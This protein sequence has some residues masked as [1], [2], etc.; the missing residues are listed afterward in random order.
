MSLSL[1]GRLA[2]LLGL[3]LVLG[4]GLTLYLT[5][6]MGGRAMIHLEEKSFATLM[7]EEQQNLDMTFISHLA[8]RVRAVQT[9]KQQ[10]QASTRQQ[11]DL[12][13]ALQTT[14]LTP[15]ERQR[16]VQAIL[17][18]SRS[19]GKAVYLLGPDDLDR[20]GLIRLGLRP[21]ARG[22]KQRT[23]YQIL[24]HLPPE[25][26]FAVVRLPRKLVSPDN[27]PALRTEEA[28]PTLIFFLPLGETLRGHVL[29]ALTSLENLDALSQN[30][31]NILVKAYRDKFAQMPLYPDGFIAL[32]DG[33]GSP[34]AQHGNMDLTHGLPLQ[35]AA[36]HGRASAT[37][38]SPHG[39][40]LCLASY[41]SAFDWYLVIAAPMAAIRAPSDVL[42]TRLLWLGLALTI[43]ATLSALFLL[44][45]AL[46]PL[47]LLTNKT[48]QLTTTDLAAPDALNQLESLMARGLPLHRRDEIGS[49]ANAFA[50]MG[51]ALATN[52][53]TLMDATSSRERLEG[54]MSAAREIQMGILPSPDTASAICGT[55][56]AAL[57]V[58]AKEVGGDLFDFFVTRDGRHCLAIGDV[59]GK[60]APAALFMAMT[61]TLAR[62]AMDSGL[63]PA[64]A[65]SKVNNLLEERNT[66]NM[67]VS[68]F[69][70]QYEPATG[71]LS[72]AN[73]GHC[74]PCII[75]AVDASPP[76]LLDNLSGPL[77]GIMPDLE[78]Q[79][80]TKHLKRGDICLLFTDGV[81]EAM[82]GQ[83]ELFG[84]ERLL[85]LLTEHRDKPP[86]ELLEC[87]FTSLVQYRGDAPQSDDITMLAFACEVAV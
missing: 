15:Q 40:I 67:F 37:L 87:I 9:A 31:K 19:D 70:A 27:S 59:S 86:R 4:V 79:L 71:V 17:S 64:A 50:N 52:I 45:Q 68:L 39:E 29:A 32:L 55:P 53:R 43:L 65:M 66:S 7:L 6:W 34:L 28:I 80:F 22:G 24:Q 83:Q 13:S 21:D 47:E 1:R 58:P 54:E 11:R 74:P 35:E 60:G 49:L 62:H 3:A 63:D 81:T 72:Y 25:G 57:L 44:M 23:L 69:L 33:Q 51:K 36:L 48:E 46:R 73:G 82:N 30:S 41:N 2:L 20:E 76:R 14:K 56:A 85:A 8:E 10:L 78:Y 77:V 16:I 12:L 84:E 18:P 75:N 26:D 5:W 38:P 42:L 61:T